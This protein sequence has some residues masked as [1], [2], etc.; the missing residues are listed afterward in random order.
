MLHKI[1][2]FSNNNIMSVTS[3]DFHGRQHWKSSRTFAREWN[4]KDISSAIL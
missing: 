4:K 3:I 1:L 2:Q